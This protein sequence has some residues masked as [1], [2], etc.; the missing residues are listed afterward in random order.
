M[1]PKALHVSGEI[2][3]ALKLGKLQFCCVSSCCRATQWKQ[4]TRRT[5]QCKRAFSTFLNI[6]N[7]VSQTR[8][9]SQCER[10]FSTFLNV[11]NK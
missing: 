11:L 3:V 8:C 7:G 6:L 10:A 2:T 9:T 1:V 4:R 5:S